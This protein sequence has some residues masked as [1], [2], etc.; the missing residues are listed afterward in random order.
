MKSL[1]FFL[2]AVGINLVL[3]IFLY[4]QPF[5]LL[6]AAVGYLTSFFVFI[7]G[8]GL[9]VS[10]S[11]S[12]EACILATATG[13]LRLY[14]TFYEI[15][16]IVA[17]TVPLYIHSW[18]KLLEKLALILVIMVGYYVLLYGSTI[19]LLQNGFNVPWLLAL[20]KFNTESFMIFA[21]GVIWFFV[22]KKEILKMIGNKS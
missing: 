6:Q 13:N 7:F 10:V 8:F 21:F 12:N 4:L 18:K 2:T 3:F 17:L 9:K 15:L 22:N 16:T 20:I 1:K 14:Q 5:N 11:L 19:L